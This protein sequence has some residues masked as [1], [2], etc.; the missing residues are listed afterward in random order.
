MTAP[1]PSQFDQIGF[2]VGAFI[3]VLK[4]VCEI[5]AITIGGIWT[6]FNFFKGRT[7]KPRLECEVDGS[8][9]THCLDLLAS[10]HQP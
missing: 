4:N 6:Y 9:E 2:G 5:A 7:Y 1:L 3:E 10:D 8:V